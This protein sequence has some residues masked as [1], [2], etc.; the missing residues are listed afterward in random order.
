MT[1]LSV[2]AARVKAG[3]TI[4]FKARGKS[5]TPR[6]ADG[7]VLTVRPW[8][9]FPDI[10]DVVLVKV[11]TRWYLHKILA[12]RPGQVQIGNNHGRINGWTSNTNVVGVTDR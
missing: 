4:T 3:E 10:G 8:A 7:D 11:R 5:M 1:N 12:T 2:L 9:V 6:I